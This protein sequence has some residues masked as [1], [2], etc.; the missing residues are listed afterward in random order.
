MKTFGM[1]LMGIL[2]LPA[3]HSASEKYAA[4]TETVE[5]AE[6]TPVSEEIMPEANMDI[7]AVPQ[8]EIKRPDKIIKE[9]AIKFEVDNYK[10]AKK[11]IDSL[12]FRWG[13][14]ISKE[15][16]R[17]SAY[18][19]T[20]TLIIRVLSKNFEKLLDAIGSTSKKIDYKTVNSIDVTEEYV[21]MEARLKTKREV[22]KRY[23]EILNRAN[24]IED[25]LKVENEIRTIREEIEA[26]EGRLKY[27]G[28]RV[29]YS[30]ITLTLYQ[31]LEYKYR[32]EKETRFFTRLYRALDKGWRGLLTFI[33]A[34]I[35]IWP[36]IVAIGIAW[37]LLVRYRKRK[38]TKSTSKK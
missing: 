25:I 28:D 21:D 14:Y 15:D 18:Q 36:L 19:V 37:I 27:L 1:L 29:A 17:Y 20:N 8:P 6:M 4:T 2:L 35:H 10:K 23:Y 11:E 3:C 9:A 34:I 32:P 7:P 26:T 13:A 16:E 22:E 12:V 5:K 30:T 31:Q 24:T 38:R 33:I